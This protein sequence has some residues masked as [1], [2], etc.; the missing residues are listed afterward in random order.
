MIIFRP[1]IYAFLILLLTLFS[2]LPAWGRII[3]NGPDHKPASSKQSV[4]EVLGTLNG[5]GV[6]VLLDQKPVVITNS[7]ILQGKKSAKIRFSPRLL[8]VLRIEDKNVTSGE[9]RAIDLNLN[10]DLKVI[11]DFPYTDFSILS[12]PETLTGPE[13]TALEYFATKNGA[14][15]LNLSKCKKGWNEARISEY[16]PTDSITSVLDGKPSSTQIV[17]NQFLSSRKKYSSS[18]PDEFKIPVYARPGASGGGYYQQAIL[19]GIV[20][21]VSLIGQPFTIAT[22]MRKIGEELTNPKEIE[23]KARWSKEGRLVIQHEDE[24]LILQSGSNAGGETGHGGGE[25]GH[26]GGDNPT[27]LYWKLEIPDA[28]GQHLIETWNPMFQRSSSFTINGEEISFLRVKNKLIIP[29]FEK[30]RS[31][32]KKLTSK[33]IFLRSEESLTFLESQR[34]K[35]P[36][37]VNQARYYNIDHSKDIYSIHKSYY[38]SDL[39][40]GGQYI[41]PDKNGE[42]SKNA[43]YFSTVNGNKPNANGYYENTHFSAKRTSGLLIDVIFTPGKA[44]NIKYFIKANSDLQSISITSN[45]K[46]IILKRVPFHSPGSVLFENGDKTI[47][48]VY[49]YDSDDLT[50]IQRVFIQLPDYLIEFGNGD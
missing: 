12:F 1:R 15:C 2:G 6:L 30:Y 8:N 18:V 35:L 46:E 11:H 13:K 49:S 17:V 3:V 25:T 26:G 32:K 4:V 38:W 40:P 16:E 27:S 39:F 5:S 50:S 29:S 9:I 21:R 23:Q 7:H 14:F 41:L 24:E 20:T 42:W 48:A 47:K 34:I 36:F 28:T 19:M 33:D 45:G 44:S 37:E 22:S 31:S 10:L 43:I